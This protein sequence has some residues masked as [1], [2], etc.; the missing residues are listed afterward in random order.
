VFSKDPRRDYISGTEQN[1]IRMRTG[2]ERVLDSSQ[3][4]RFRL[5]IYCELL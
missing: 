3:G 1:E 4:T 2:M 5:K